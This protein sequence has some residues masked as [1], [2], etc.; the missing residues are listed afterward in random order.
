MRHPSDRHLRCLGIRR[1][2]LLA[3]LVFALTSPGCGDGP[4]ENGAPAAVDPKADDRNKQY[5][6]YMTSQ[7]KSKGLKVKKN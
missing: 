1:H 7:S 4:S 2:W 5:N 3:P 6:D